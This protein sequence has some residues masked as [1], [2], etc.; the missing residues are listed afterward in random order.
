MT[1][2][3][4]SVAMPVRNVAATVDLAIRSIAEQTFPDWELVVV[5]DGSTDATPEILTRWS[6]AD[7]RVRTH[8]DGA[9]RGISAR[10]NEAVRLARGELVARMD[11][12][13]ISFPQ[14][15]EVQV[16]YLRAHP[17]VD[18]LGAGE[19]VFASTGEL[20]GFRTA[21]PDHPAITADVLGGIPVSHPTWVGRREW[22]LR[23]PY[24]PA[25]T[26]CE[27]QELLLRAHATSTYANVPDVLLAY[28]EDRIKLR[29][30]LAA[31]AATAAYLLRHGR[32]G[33]RLAAGAAAAAGQLARGARDAAAVLL[34]QEERVMRGRVTPPRPGDEQTWQVWRPVV[35]AGHP[36]GSG[37]PGPDA[38][39][40]P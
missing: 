32:T 17:D 39:P 30:S 22:F 19:M 6:A 24:D 33:G 31:R 37:A 2:P 25:A 21:P 34:H 11:G 3:A 29:R 36:D 18:L 1:A 26:A 10:L 7:A 28:R 12:D 15:L 16:G 13:D 8:V 4:V 5:D 14:R 35:L 27:D 9:S 40:E 38:G 23:N 20:R